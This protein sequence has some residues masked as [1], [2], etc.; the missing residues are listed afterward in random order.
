MGPRE[1]SPVAE[2]WRNRT[3]YPALEVQYPA[4]RVV[5]LLSLG[6][7]LL[8]WT[9][10]SVS[11]AL[12]KTAETT[13]TITVVVVKS[14]L[15][16][17]EDTGDFTLELGRGDTGSESSTQ[18][19]NYRIKGNSFPAAALNGVVSA[20][21][22]SL[23]EGLELQADVGSFANVGTQGNIELYEEKAGF[24]AVGTALVGL[25]SKKSSSGTQA[26]VLNGTIPITW[27]V[28]ATQDLP[29]QQV[30]LALTVT[31]KD[32]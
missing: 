9:L 21:V 27:K 12:G 22:S 31:L 5:F 15:S 30:P 29:A 20:K 11:P 24:Q 1:G 16:I 32:V 18:V 26:K 25:A 10:L 6:L 17:T 13:S 23:P 28:E 2:T 3:A 19:V 14:A 7:A 4:G 8:G